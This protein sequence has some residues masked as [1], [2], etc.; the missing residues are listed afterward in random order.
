V[1]VRLAA[2]EF[3]AGRIAKE[4]VHRSREWLRRLGFA[5]AA[6]SGAAP[7]RHLEEMRS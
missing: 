7:Y 1:G 6:R 2:V 3:A 5:M 4:V